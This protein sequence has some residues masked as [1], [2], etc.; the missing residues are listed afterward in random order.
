MSSAF[1]VYINNDL[2]L[3]TG[4]PGKNA[5]ETTPFY[6][7]KVVGFENNSESFDI[8][9]HVSNF[10]YRMGG[11]WAPVFLGKPSILNSMRERK[12]VIFSFFL[13]QYVLLGFII[14]VFFGLVEMINLLCILVYSVY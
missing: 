11:M 4:I 10:H 14:L 13:E 7:P 2:L 12:L 5:K 6:S 9:I 8:I 3:S 1:R